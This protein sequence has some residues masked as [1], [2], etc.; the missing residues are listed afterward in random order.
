MV[1][2]NPSEDG[3]V[4]IQGSGNEPDIINA[5]DYHYTGKVSQEVSTWE[6]K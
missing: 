5:D 2:S 3:A 4:L 1:L 6:R